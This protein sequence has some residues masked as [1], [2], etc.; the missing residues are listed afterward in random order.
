MKTH[1]QRIVE[2]L[3]DAGIYWG[4]SEGNKIVID[5]ATLVFRGD[6]SLAGAYPE[7]NEDDEDDF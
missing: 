7:Q 2:I 3:E 6:D 5:Y 1:K 4:Y